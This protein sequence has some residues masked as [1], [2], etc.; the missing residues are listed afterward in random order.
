MRCPSSPKADL[1]QPWGIRAVFDSRRETDHDRDGRRKGGRIDSIITGEWRKVDEGRES[2][3]DKH[4][5][6]ESKF[7]GRTGEG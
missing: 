5:K 4:I 1:P 2:V 7:G 6:L 3:R